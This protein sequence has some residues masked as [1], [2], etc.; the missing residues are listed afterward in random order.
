MFRI[1]K[2]IFLALIIYLNVIASYCKRSKKAECSFEKNL[3]DNANIRYFEVS[4]TSNT[5]LNTIKNIREHVSLL[6]KY[7]DQSYELA[8]NST[9]LKNSSSSLIDDDILFLESFIS[10]F[11]TQSNISAPFSTNGVTIDSVPIHETNCNSDLIF[12]TNNEDINISINNHLISK[13]IPDFDQINR[14][15]SVI[16]WKVIDNIVLN[17][18]PEIQKISYEFALICTS[19]SNNIELLKSFSNGSDIKHVQWEAL[20]MASFAR[21]YSRYILETVSLAMSLVLIAPDSKAEPSVL[22]DINFYSIIKHP[23]ELLNKLS[24][25]KV[26][27]KKN[28]ECID[29]FVD[30]D[31]KNSCIFCFSIFLTLYSRIQCQFVEVGISRESILGIRWLEEIHSHINQLDKFLLSVWNHF[32]IEK[33]PNSSHYIPPKPTISWKAFKLKLYEEFRIGL[34]FQQKIKL[35]SELDLSDHIFLNRRSKKDS[36]INNYIELKY[37]DSISNI[38]ELNQ[39]EIDV[40][41]ETIKVYNN[42]I[43]LMNFSQNGVLLG[44]ITKLSNS[45]M[46][47]AIIL[48]TYG[49][50]HLINIALQSLKENHRDIPSEECKRLHR[51]VIID[52]YFDQ[53]TLTNIFV[54]YIYCKNDLSSQINRQISLHFKYELTK[55]FLK[56]ILISTRNSLFDRIRE[57]VS[58]SKVNAEI[59]FKR[60][61]TRYLSQ[62][63]VIL[64]LVKIIRIKMDETNAKL[65][66][67]LQLTDY[68][69]LNLEKFKIKLTSFIFNNRYFFLEKGVIGELN[70][71]SYPLTPITIS[72]GPYLFDIA[73]KNL[74]ATINKLRSK[75]SLLNKL[76]SFSRNILIKRRYNINEGLNYQ[77]KNKILYS[78]ALRIYN[79]R[80]ELIVI[81]TFTMVLY[82][83]LKNLGNSSLKPVK[84]EFISENYRFDFGK[85]DRCNLKSDIL[86]LKETE[87][88]G[89][90]LFNKM[91]EIIQI[92]ELFSLLQ[93]Q[94][95]IIDNTERKIYYEISVLFDKIWPHRNFINNILFKNLS[96]KLY[97]L[98]SLLENMLIFNGIARN[99]LVPYINGM[100]N[101]ECLYDF[102]LGSISSLENAIKEFPF[103]ISS[104]GPKAFFKNITSAIKGIFIKSERTK[105]REKKA[106]VKEVTRLSKIL[107]SLEPYVI[108]IDISFK[109]NVEK[110]RFIKIESQERI[111]KLFYLY[112]HCIY[113]TLK[114]TIFVGN[115]EKRFPIEV[116]E[117]WNEFIKQLNIVQASLFGQLYLILV[118]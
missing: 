118:S 7:N 63:Q 56:R 51:E 58:A 41:E 111:R 36:E 23:K 86:S 33:Y 65:N 46:S 42:I 14:T 96:S 40:I 31:I 116:R 84:N 88:I 117:E 4:V 62:F 60:S 25:Q 3:E 12:E 43:E 48:G 49:D 78:T 105:N 30:K 93:K 34:N 8:G 11:S 77:E 6:E 101:F 52:E 75:I 94:F 10:S 72:L 98:K 17:L 91:V 39:I 100:N 73:G 80:D 50:K 18:V 81:N 64:G 79:N 68:Y 70:D 114:S 5:E 20:Q 82:K 21:G 2:L 87:L 35:N 26:E 57:R 54:K 67:L 108:N 76:I 13:L 113:S 69:I 115:L 32:V 19:I 85:D 83:T 22:S 44:S 102:S 106:I 90:K 37:M 112:I 27:E 61:F 97:T 15:I 99:S 55:K 38:L 107:F 109:L 103:N 1:K 110:L 71:T 28:Y 45:L 47:I 104:K 66:E 29:F 16:P 89:C 24:E 74:R 9:N 53:S 95:I 59:N 92:D